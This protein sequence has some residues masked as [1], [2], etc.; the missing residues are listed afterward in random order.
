MCV[1]LELNTRKRHSTR[2]DRA[3]QESEGRALEIHHRSNHNVD[4]CTGLDTSSNCNSNCTSNRVAYI[5]VNEVYSHY[6]WL[7]VM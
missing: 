2:Q 7:T 1:K 5:T 3:G 4:S 6:H